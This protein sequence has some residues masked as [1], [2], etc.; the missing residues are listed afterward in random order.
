MLLIFRFPKN[1]FLFQ[2]DCNILTV[3]IYSVYYNIILA[4]VPCLC[5]VGI[6]KDKLNKIKL[7]INTKNSETLR[8]P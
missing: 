1:I 5:P 4:E 3:N 2:I 8:S 6:N 7:R